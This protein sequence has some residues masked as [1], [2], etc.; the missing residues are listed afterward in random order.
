MTVQLTATGILFVCGVLLLFNALP[1]NRWFGLRTART[2]AVATVWY[3]A[4]RAFGLVF[5]VTS[6]AIGGL[7]LLPDMPAQPAWAIGG[8]LALAIAFVLMYRRYAA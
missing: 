6:V 4:H 8:V 7:G 2:L 5:V 3:R 1:P